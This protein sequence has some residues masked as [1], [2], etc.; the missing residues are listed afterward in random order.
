MLRYHT[1]KKFTSLLAGVIFSKGGAKRGHMRVLCTENLR[2]RLKIAI[3]KL[4]NQLSKYGLIDVE[5]QILGTF[6]IVQTF[7]SLQNG[8]G[9]VGI[10]L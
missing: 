3:C 9:K 10:Y 5:A 7:E 1:N 2:K 8:L 4:G 6:L